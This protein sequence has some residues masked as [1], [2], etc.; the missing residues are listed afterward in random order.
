[1][2]I[3]QSS[4]RKTGTTA[5]ASEELASILQAEIIHLSDHELSH[6]NY[7]GPGSDNFED[8]INTIIKHKEVVFATPIYWYTM[9]GMLKF[10]LDR[11]SDLLKWNKDLGRKIR[12]LKMHVI[13]V[14][15]HDDPPEHFTYPFEM[16]ADYL[17][18]TFGNY[19]HIC[20]GKEDRIAVFAEKISID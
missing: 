4:H 12:G 3:I 18:M 13:S 8:L 6:F 11:I 1:M 17:G 9:S 10:F 5:A 20:P 7:E 14:S 2:V 19:V 15:G 16:T